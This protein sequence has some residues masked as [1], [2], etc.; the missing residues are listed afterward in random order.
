ML[1]CEEVI[2]FLELNNLRHRADRAFADS[3]LRRIGSTYNPYR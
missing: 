1:A 2:S 3:L